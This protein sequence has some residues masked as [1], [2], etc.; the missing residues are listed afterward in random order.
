M[1]RSRL[2]AAVALAAW[3]AITTTSAVLADSTPAPTTSPAPSGPAASCQHLDPKVPGGLPARLGCDVATGGPGGPLADATNSAGQAASDAGQAVFQ[4]AETGFTNWLAAGAAA[5]AQ[6]VLAKLT[7]PSNTP[8][9]DPA[10]AA[11]FAQVYGRVVG[12]ALSLSVLL[13]LIG[14]IEAVLTQRPGGL[15]RVV[16]GIA[17]SGIGMGAVPVAT[18]I[19]IR[20]VDDLSQYVASGQTQAITQGM[21]TTIQ[22]LRTQTGAGDAGAAFAWTAFGILLGGT[23]LWLELVTREGLIYLYVAIVPLACAAAQWPRLEGVLRQVL[24]GGLALILSKLLITIALSVGFA[25]MATS[26]TQL[27]TLLAGTFVLLLAALTPFA[28]ARVLPIAAEELG[29]HSQGR[30]RGALV[31][32]AG[33]TSRMVTSIATGGVAA[34]GGLASLGLA[35]AM[36]SSPAAASAPPSR[37]QERPSERRGS[38]PQV[39]SAGAN[40][41]G[42]PAQGGPGVDDPA[43]GRRPHVSRYSGYPPSRNGAVP[44]PVGGASPPAA[45]R[46]P[47]PPRSAA[48][49]VA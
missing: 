40:G 34:G 46:G 25:V 42:A 12:V 30:L 29:H 26:N 43:S 24:F 48:S 11:A 5:V 8:T 22:L 20:I 7:G 1:A 15:R 9:L 4:S 45:P 14:V 3:L 21:Q 49:P 17:V 39:A 32:G 33:S 19:L 35:R 6:G 36:G 38:T 10:H 23:L 31:G 13:I 37:S 44:Q 28:L 16:V 2:A 47:E 18:D 27:E 41:T